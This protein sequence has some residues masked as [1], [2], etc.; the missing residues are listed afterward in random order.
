MDGQPDRRHREMIQAPSSLDASLWSRIEAEARARARSN[1][2][3]HDFF[4]VERVMAN[5]CAIAR[6]EGLS[7]ER[8]ASAVTA[9]LLHELFTLPKD[10]PDSSR[11]GDRCADH[12]RDVLERE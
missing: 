3:A 7:A 1:E 11:A 8:E 12:A 6:D 4:H 9:A 2:P 10:H 5:A